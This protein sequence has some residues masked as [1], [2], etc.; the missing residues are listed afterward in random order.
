ML[1]GIEADHANRLDRTGVEE[2]C[3]QIIQHLKKQIPLEERVVLYSRSPLIGELGD[4]PSNWENKILPWK[5][6]KLWSQFRLSYEFLRHPPDVFFAPA[7]MVPLIYPKNTIVMVHDSAFMAEPKA[8]NFWGRQYLKWMNT[9]IVHRA[10]LVVTSTEFNKKEM[11]KYY[12][13]EEAKIEVVP[14]AYDDSRFKLPPSEENA[15]TISRKYSL[16]Q[17]YLLFTG[18]LERK[19]N[20]SRIVRAFGILKHNNAGNQHI[21]N[22]QLVLAGKPGVGYN[23]IKSAIADSFYKSDIKLL[24]WVD[25]DGLPLLMS[26]AA[27][28]IF[29]SLYEGFG[30]PI[31]EA[32]ACGC[33]VV[34]SVGSALPEVGGDAA[35]YVNPLD[36]D[37]MAREIFNL[38]T[39]EAKRNKLISNGFERVKRYSWEKT[40][41]R[42]AEIICNAEIAK[43]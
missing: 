35:V 43:L 36:V 34:A 4:L 6:K 21:N 16:R 3:W 14:L 20:A 19:K 17:S 10:K 32:M 29:P 12:S 18:R 31:L 39:D 25:G 24:G 37:D 2:Y 13:V 41:A 27:A 5:F 28:F 9:K 26:G 8:Y 7:Q 15:N 40:A 22:L 30:I 38:V 42:L 23:E 1:I 33:P 11:L